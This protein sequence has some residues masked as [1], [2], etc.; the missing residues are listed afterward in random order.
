MT[1][2]AEIKGGE[3]LRTYLADLAKKVTAPGTLRVG[4]LEGS[5]YEDGTPVAMVAAIQNFGAP[6][7]GIPPRPFFS[8]MVKDHRDEWGPQIGKLLQANDFDA[9]KSL[10][11]MGERIGDELRQSI[12]DTNEPPL[13]P[14]TIARK[15]FDKPLIDTSVMW[16]SI[17][18]E[19]K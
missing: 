12:Q 11:T 3:K 14:A 18:H 13:K 5:D 17:D 4:F 10:D 19:I 2:M 1:P 6:R 9:T 15:G 16:K 8:N 7:A